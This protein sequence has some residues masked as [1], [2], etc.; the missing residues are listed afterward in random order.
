MELF[1]WDE[2]TPE[3]PEGPGVKIYWVID[4]KRGAE[5]FAMRVLEVAPGASSQYHHHWY[6]QEMYLLEGQGVATSVEGERPLSPGT[7]L[8]VRPNEPHAFKNTG[9][10]PMKFICCVP[11]KKP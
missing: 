7:V 11:T 1:K 4:K 6:E 10:A 8:W 3:T 9:S 5:N 2:V